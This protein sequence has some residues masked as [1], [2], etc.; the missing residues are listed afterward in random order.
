LTKDSVDK[1]VAVLG[2][3]KDAWA[4]LPIPEKIGF[5]HSLRR[6]TGEVA[7]RWV[8]AAVHAKGI[9]SD[10]P[11]AGEEWFS[12]PYAF[13]YGINAIEKTMQAL[14]RG[15]VPDLKPGTVRVRPDGQLVVQ[16][17][18]ADLYDRMLLSGVRAEVWMNREVTA[19]NLHSHMAGFYRQYSPEGK[20]ALVLGA[21]NIA[22][23]APLDLLHKLFSEGQVCILKM[24]PV[25]EYLGPIFEEVFDD[26][27]Q[28][29]F[30]RFAYGGAEVGSYLVGHSVVDEIHMTGSERTYDSI[31]FGSGAKGAE[32]KRCNEPVNSKRFTAELGGIGPTIVLPGSWSDADIQFQ[33]EHI[34]TQKLHNVGFNCVASQVLVLPA[35]WGRKNQLLDALRATIRSIPPRKAYYPGAQHRQKEVVRV[36]PGAELFDA[37]GEGVVPRTLVAGLNPGDASNHGFTEEFFCSALLQTALPGDTPAKFLREAVRFANGALRGSLGANFIVHPATLSELGPDFETAIADLRYGTIGV[38]GWVGVA[39]LLPQAT[40][41]AFPGHADNDIQS[42]RGVVHNSLQFDKPERTVVYAPFEPFPRC[43]T[44][45]RFS[46]LPKP[47]WFVTHRRA[48]EVGRRLTRFAVNPGLLHLPGIFGA[49]LRG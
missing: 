32:R 45:G 3:R 10:S 1:A 25:N 40:W 43:L 20:V 23:I 29:G 19:G 13:L 11:W 15:R 5:L 44:K 38:N 16:V 31:R 35:S 2:E 36:Y 30:V 33:A 6:R 34:A 27:V 4:Q 8:K 7:D 49:A 26:L 39:F 41:G 14:A 12:G 9:P 17:F 24:N 46:L 18:P 42:G 28:R 37:P 21:G 48:D 47:P 22:S